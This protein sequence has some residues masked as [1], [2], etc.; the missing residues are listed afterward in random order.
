MKAPPHIVI[1]PCGKWHRTPIRGTEEYD[2]TF[3]CG[4]K[5][6]LIPMQGLAG[7]AEFKRHGVCASIVDLGYSNRYLFIILEIET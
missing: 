7:G 5:V 2:F 3:E 6:T 1:C 4:L